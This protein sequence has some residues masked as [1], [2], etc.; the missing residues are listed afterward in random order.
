MQFVIQW[1][2]WNENSN[3]VFLFLFL[4]FISLLKLYNNEYRLFCDL[5][6]GCLSYSHLDCSTTIKIFLGLRGYFILAIENKLLHGSINTSMNRL[7]KLL[8]GYVSH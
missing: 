1:L 5:I 4:F 2:C 6:Y 8:F 3:N 7:T